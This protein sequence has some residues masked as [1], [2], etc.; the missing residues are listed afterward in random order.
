MG[1]HQ[2]NISKQGQLVDQNY[3]NGTFFMAMST[4][5]EIERM[6]RGLDK[7]QKEFGKYDHSDYSWKDYQQLKN[8][9]KTQIGLV[10]ISI[11]EFDKLHQ[12]GFSL[13]KNYDLQKVMDRLEKTKNLLSDDKDMVLMCRDLQSLVNKQYNQINSYQMNFDQ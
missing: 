6:A 3:A 4:I 12:S 13:P 11:F 1:Q 5:E 7:G 9:L 2:A 10:H 8:Q